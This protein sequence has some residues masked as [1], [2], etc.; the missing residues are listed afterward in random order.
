MKNQIRN[1]EKKNERKIKNRKSQ[2][3]V[4]SIKG[5][6]IRVQKKKNVVMKKRKILAII[7]SIDM[8]N[9]VQVH[10]EIIIK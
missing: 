5:G 2:K 4:T 6:M 1:L 7:A 9:I 3:R 10:M 8:I